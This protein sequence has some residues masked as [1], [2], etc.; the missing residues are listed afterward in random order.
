MKKY[1]V[2]T[3]VSHKSEGICKIISIIDINGSSFYK[4]ESKN[5]FHNI[6][7]SPVDK[8]EQPFRDLITKEEITQLLDYMKSIKNFNVDSSKKRRETFKEFL[9]SNDPKKLIYLF[10]SLYLYKILKEEK[11]QILSQEDKFI[12]KKAHSLLNDEFSLVLNLDSSDVNKFF[13][14]SL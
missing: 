14:A 4:L 5:N 12:Y 2:G 7:Y 8:E 10:K 13:D 6:V 1:E 9:Y 3:Y 11:N